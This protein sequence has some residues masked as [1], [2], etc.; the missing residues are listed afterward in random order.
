MTKMTRTDEDIEKICRQLINGQY[1]KRAFEVN[2][3]EFQRFYTTLIHLRKLNPIVSFVNLDNL[4][5]AQF[6]DISPQHFDIFRIKTLTEKDFGYVVNKHWYGATNKQN[7]FLKFLVQ[8]LT[9]NWGKL[10]IIFLISFALLGLVNS[11]HFYELI[12]TFLIQSGTIFLS[13]YIIFTVSQSQTL[14]H[15]M[16]LFKSGVLQKYYSDDKNITILGILT[17]GLIF[18]SSGIVA[19]LTH[20]K[21]LINISWVILTARIIKAFLFGFAITLLFDT[22][23]T[24][25][26]YYLERN[27]DVIERDLIA[28]LLDEEFT[29][30]SKPKNENLNN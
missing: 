17:I 14:Y 25:A 22:F 26:T 19:L 24:V 6:S 15:D 5:V 21:E 2:P 29:Q 12:G 10:L 3:D 11:D 28:D 18:F 4:V 8:E 9:H 1:N 20:Y 13:L 30:F 16:T 27:R 23:F 7:G